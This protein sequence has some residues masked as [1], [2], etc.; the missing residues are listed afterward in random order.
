MTRPEASHFSLKLIPLSG[1]SS[2]CEP[3]LRAIVLLSSVEFQIL[4]KVSSFILLSLF[5]AKEGKPGRRWKN[6][7]H[8]ATKRKSVQAATANLLTMTLEK[9]PVRCPR[10]TLSYIF[11]ERPGGRS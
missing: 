6:N 4:R 10:K 1:Y 5:I 9:L 8:P 3:S 7:F 11:F 2:T